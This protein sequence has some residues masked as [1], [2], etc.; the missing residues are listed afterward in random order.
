MIELADLHSLDVGLAIPAIST[1][2]KLKATSAA[3]IVS[4]IAMLDL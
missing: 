4:K 2:R 3:D 1:R